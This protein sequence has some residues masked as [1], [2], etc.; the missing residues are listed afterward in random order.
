MVWNDLII[1]KY[2][3]LRSIED[4]E[5][6]V[7]FSLEI[8]QNENKTRYLHRV[9][10][11][12][13][14]QRSWIQKQRKREGDYFFIIEQPSGKKVGTVGIYDIEDR[15]A[16]IGRVLM[17]GNPVETFESQLLA[18]QFAYEKLGIEE[19]FS[20]ICLENAA[21]IRLAKALEFHFGD[22]IF[23]NEAREQVY[24]GWAY[25]S[26]FPICKERISKLIYR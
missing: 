6:D 10:N 22:P 13:E 7:A 1:G 3:R 15:V 20:I 8:R 2:V 17:I 21:S 14:Q 4:L 19:L 18:M 23:L 11:N 16:Q 9:E 24:Q 25:K 26:E 5:D 12:S